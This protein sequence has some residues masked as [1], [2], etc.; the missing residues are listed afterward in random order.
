MTKYYYAAA[1]NEALENYLAEHHLSHADQLIVLVRFDIE[2]GMRFYDHGR[3][4]DPLKKFEY[5][6]LLDEIESRGIPFDVV[7]SWDEAR[8][9]LKNKC[10]EFYMSGSYLFKR[11]C[12]ALEYAVSLDEDDKVIWDD[13]S[14][15]NFEEADT[16]KPFWERQN[17]EDEEEE[18]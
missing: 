4:H 8:R 18:E 1:I 2:I 14:C 13:D 15:A 3:L 5:R 7:T 6:D 9:Q 12:A 10:C 11:G 17:E 16:L